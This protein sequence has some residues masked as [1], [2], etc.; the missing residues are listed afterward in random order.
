MIPK[1]QVS[2]DGGFKHHSWQ[3]NIGRYC[4]VISHAMMR[5]SPSLNI[6]L[7]PTA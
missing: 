1:H 7:W 2:R 5:M 3:I 6:H 4:C